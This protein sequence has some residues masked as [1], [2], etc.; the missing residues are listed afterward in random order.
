[1]EKKY[2]KFIEFLKV[3]DS[4]VE[5]KIGGNIYVKGYDDD[6][7]SLI[8]MKVFSYNSIDGKENGKDK[9]LEPPLIQDLN[10]MINFID[11]NLD[12]DELELSMLDVVLN[13]AIIHKAKT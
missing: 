1:M 11:K 10:G 8:A 9:L 3:I 5:I 2:K 12:D 7:K 6:D 4:G 13:K